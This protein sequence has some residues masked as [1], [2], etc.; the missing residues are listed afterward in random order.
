MKLL[1]HICCGP[2]SLKVIDKIREKVDCNIQGYYYNP[3]I[4]PKSEFL[5]R[6]QTTSQ[7][8]GAKRIAL[9]IND[10]YDIRSWQLFD[11]KK[12][13]RCEMCY[14]RR[15]EATAKF[16]AENGFTHFTTTLLVSPYQDHE[17]LKEI[18]NEMAEKYGVGFYYDDFRDVYRDG[19]KEAHD[20]G[21]YRQKYCGCVLSFADYEARIEVKKK[22]NEKITATTLNNYE[23]IAADLEAEKL[24]GKKYLIKNKVVRE[25][26]S[27]TLTIVA[28]FVIALI[29]N[30]Y[31]FRISQ[32][33][34]ISM[35]QTYQGGERVYMSRLPYIFGDPEQGDIIVFDSSMIDRNFF[36]D[37]K[38]SVKFNAITQALFDV[39]PPKKYY[40]KRVIAVE[41]DTIRLTEEGV[42][43][44]GEL[45]QE[46]YVNPDEAPA[47]PIPGAMFE[48]N[49]WLKALNE[50]L[51][52]PED[53]VF[54]MGDN[55]NH[56]TD[57][58]S[59]GFVPVND[60]LGKVFD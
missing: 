28:A 20:M 6:L 25:L 44:N 36:T 38:E 54:V 15:L 3:N 43:V 8:C 22:N 48:S 50:G 18:G 32:V 14:R 56:S 9:N 27:W 59:L 45:L 51:V 47:Y 52:V 55:R 24:P 34:G 39:P 21:M 13:N 41:G 30:T 1:L 46:N 60:I 16:A 2:C 58:R 19:Q 7:A 53:H 12:G 42:Y 26:L 17:K 5:R 23:M 31:V 4:H 49:D 40:I 57:S 11:E 10:E 37:V 29:I 33:S 35:K